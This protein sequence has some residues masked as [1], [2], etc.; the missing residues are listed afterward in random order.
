VIEQFPLTTPGA[1]PETIASGPDGAV[2]FTQQV[3]DSSSGT[4]GLSIARITTDGTITVYPLPADVDG[5]PDMTGGPDADVW[6]TENLGNQNGA[7][8]AEAIGRITPQGVIQTFAVP[9]RKSEQTGGLGALAVGPDGNIWF[10]SDGAHGASFIG[11]VTA[12]GKI[13]IFTLPANL[14]TTS[15]T[16]AYSGS[17]ITQ[18]TSSLLAGADGKIWFA[19]TEK[20]KPGIARISTKGKL[21]QFIPAAIEGGLVEGPS[22]VVWFP[23]SPKLG[24]NPEL[25]LATKKGIVVTPDVAGTDSPGYNSYGS[26]GDMTTGPDGNLWFTDGGTNIVRISGL[27]TPIGGLDERHRPKH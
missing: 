10:A 18:D 16:P 27:D 8:F 2:W 25:M 11:R 17:Y 20:G 15:S 1:T 23:G 12:R 9:V 4:S 7:I 14:S 13:R 3:D 22:G 19:A 5:V 6:F 26:Q 24:T 21:G